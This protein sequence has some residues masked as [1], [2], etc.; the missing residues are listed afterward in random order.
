[1]A[2]RHKCPQHEAAPPFF[3]TFVVRSLQCPCKVCFSLHGTHKCL[4]DRNIFQI[5]PLVDQWFAIWHKLPDESI[6]A[7]MLLLQLAKAPAIMQPMSYCVNSP[8]D[9]PRSL[10]HHICNIT[11]PRSG[12]YAA[13]YCYAAIPYKCKTCL[14]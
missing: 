8:C 2:A 3:H 6:E 7:A 1:M 9:K 11:S 4:L 10:L 5:A 12:G 14:L 13:M